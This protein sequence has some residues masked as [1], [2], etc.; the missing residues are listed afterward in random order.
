MIRNSQIQRTVLGRKFIKVVFQDIL[1]DPVGNLVS[2]V[3][4][5]TS[6]FQAIIAVLLAK[7][8]YANA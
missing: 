7:L 5:L 4:P 1:N 3:R 8:Q 6:C 2:L